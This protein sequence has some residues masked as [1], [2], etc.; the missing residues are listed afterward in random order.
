MIAATERSSVYLP[1]TC[2][3]GPAGV[4][5]KC[6][7]CDGAGYRLLSHNGS[8]KE[9]LCDD[10]QAMGFT[11]LDPSEPTDCAPGSAGKIIVMQARYPRG[12]PL[13]H[14]DDALE[15]AA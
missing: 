4:A 13:F 2:D 9:Q 7:S 8:R 5:C 14:D 11:G 15:H 3:L 1:D 12:L 10:C 6:P